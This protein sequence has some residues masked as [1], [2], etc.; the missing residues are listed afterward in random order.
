MLRVGAF[1][2]SV[3]WP[4]AGA[5]PIFPQYGASPARSPQTSWGNRLPCA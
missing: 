2:G 5:G 4:A 3:E 1:V